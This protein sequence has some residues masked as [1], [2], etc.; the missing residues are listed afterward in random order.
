MKTVKSKKGGRKPKVD[1][2]CVTIAVRLSAKEH[3]ELLN[4]IDK[5]EQN[6]KSKF[7]RS[8][9]FGKEISVVKIDNSLYKVIEWLTKVHSQYRAIGT[10][11]NQTV[12]YIK[13]CFGE[14]RAVLLL[15]NLEKCTANLIKLSEQISLVAE[16]LKKKYADSSNKIHEEI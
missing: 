3:T 12:K 1:K 7:I 11:Y 16:G 8:C 15:K 13:S 6:N 9:I 5:F 10:N 14:K 2:Q 4:L